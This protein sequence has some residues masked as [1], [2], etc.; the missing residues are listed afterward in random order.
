M[1]KNKGQNIIKINM[2]LIIVILIVVSI[3]LI[4]FVFAQQNQTLEDELAQLENELSSQGYEWLTDYNVSYPYIE[5]YEFNKTEKIAEF[6]EISEGLYKIYLMNLSENENY[7][8]DVFD[9]RVVNLDGN[10]E[11]IPYEIMQKKIRLD[12]IRKELDGK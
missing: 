6:P 11:K 3:S 12:K 4:G 5:V 10:S 1:V 2:K 8:Q 7:S 9:L